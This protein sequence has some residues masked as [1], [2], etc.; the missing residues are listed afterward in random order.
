MCLA[1]WRKPWSDREDYDF[2][3]EALLRRYNHTEEGYRKRFCESQQEN[4][5]TPQYIWYDSKPILRT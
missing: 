2:A 4:G 5:E 1:V 3:K